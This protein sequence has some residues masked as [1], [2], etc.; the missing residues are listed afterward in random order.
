MS[1]EERIYVSLKFPGL[2]QHNCPTR[3]SDK[4]QSWYFKSYE[5]FQPYEEYMYPYVTHFI[6]IPN[7][8]LPYVRK[9]CPS[10]F[11]NHATKIYEVSDDDLQKLKD[12]FPGK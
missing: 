1:E 3:W 8:D 6:K 4:Y 9:H 7:E 12:M 5:D 10:M 2:Q 11:Y